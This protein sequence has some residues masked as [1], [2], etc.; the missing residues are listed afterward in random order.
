MVKVSVVT[1][2]MNNIKGLEVTYNSIKSQ[3]DADME[4]V[5]VDGCSTD[6][7]VEF[8]DRISKED[9][10]VIYISEKDSGIYNALNKGVQLSSG[11]YIVVLGGG[12]CFY[13]ETTVSEM[14]DYLKYDVVYGKVIISSG[15]DEGKLFGDKVNRWMLISGKA[16]AHQSVFA[17][18]ELL[19]KYPFDE[20]FYL[21]ADQDFMLKL[22]FK[23]CSMLFINKIVSSYDGLGV[24]SDSKNLSIHLKERLIILKKYSKI[25]YV[26]KC[27][28]YKIRYR[29]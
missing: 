18:R 25:L 12:D 10:R 17:K 6:G 19:I 11:E 24:S 22:Y 16:V 29:L 21:T 14:N 23:K 9:D 4:F 28:Y 5:V 7:T 13:N 3:K 1:A 20:S 2:V 15:P 27:V 26:L 8:L